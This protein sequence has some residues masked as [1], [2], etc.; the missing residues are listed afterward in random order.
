MLKMLVVDDDEVFLQAM[1]TFLRLKLPTVQIDVSISGHEALRLIQ[2]DGY[3]LIIADWRMPGMDG[4]TFLKVA[5]EGSPRVP[6]ILLTG[7]HDEAM[8]R[9]AK[10]NGAYAVLHKPIERDE[11]FRH[12]AQALGVAALPTNNSGA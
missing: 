11:L 1:E 6:V 3:R 10:S 8:V 9:S 4:V 2:A 5:K 7:Q 12:I